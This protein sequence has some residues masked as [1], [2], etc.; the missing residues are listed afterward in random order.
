MSSLARKFS[1]N[2]YNFCLKESVFTPHKV[3]TSSGT[4]D[5]EVFHKRG[6]SV[7]WWGGRVK[8]ESGPP[9]LLT[10]LE[11]PG[12]S[13]AHTALGRVIVGTRFRFWFLELI[14]LTSELDL[15]Q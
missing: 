8:G 13:P 1:S 7:V 14:S 6:A 5:T 12:F 15:L 2:Y 3:E 10:L 11:S 4:T 9:R